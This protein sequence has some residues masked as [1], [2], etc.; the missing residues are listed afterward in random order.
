[1]EKPRKLSRALTVIGAIVLLL[2]AYGLAYVLLGN[3][4]TI[5]YNG[6]SFSYRLYDSKWKATLFT[7]AAKAESLMTNKEISTVWPQQKKR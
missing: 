3:S 7:P 2:F 5:T 1:M 6:Q 4:D